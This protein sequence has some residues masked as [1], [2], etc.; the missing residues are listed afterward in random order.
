MSRDENLESLL[1][2]ELLEEKIAQ[3]PV[4]YNATRSSSKLLHAQSSG[5]NLNI[6]E[7]KFEQVVE[8][9][10]EGDLLVLNNSKVI[11]ARFFLELPGLKYAEIL[12]VRPLSEVNE[13]ECLGR[14]LKKLENLGTFN[15]SK[16]LRC[17]VLDRTNEGRGL[18]IKLE[19]VDGSELAE[20]IREEGF[21]PIPPYIRSGKSDA[22]DKDLYQTVYAK[23]EGSVAAPTAGLHFT[24]EILS[25]LKSKG[26]DSV[27]VTLHV[28]PYSFFPVADKI[29]ES[30][31]L[32]ERFLVPRET[33]DAIKS[34]KAE[35]RRVIAVGTTVVRCLETFYGLDEIDE[36]VG[37]WQES[38]LMIMPGFS[39][40]VIDSMFTNFHQPRSTHLLLVGAFLGV[41]NMHKVYQYA[42]SNNFRFLS[43]GD[44]S[45]LEKL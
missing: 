27:N 32:T 45:F 6:S 15:L 18:R 44:S 29:E 14:P 19:V 17:T 35:G 42:L 9:L 39:F 2:Y 3:R 16:K 30:Q 31:V 43:Y 26:V 1:S 10:K 5:E 37:K 25:E 7:Y 4:S 21:A 34:A 23:E 20:V 22:S 36:E 8:L 24:E 13:W 41:D 40:K 11:H 12:L 28:G 38:S 33:F